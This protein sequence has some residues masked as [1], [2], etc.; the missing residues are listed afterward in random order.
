MSLILDALHRSDQERNHQGAVPGIQTLHGASEIGDSRPRWLLWGPVGLLCLGGL[1]VW[2]LRDGVGVNESALAAV[3]NVS[4]PVTG[5]LPGTTEASA[6]PAVP[7]ATTLPEP[8]PAARP[9]DGVAELYQ[10]AAATDS[11]ANEAAPGPRETAP[12]PVDAMVVAAQQELAAPP[13][14]DNPTPLLQDLPQRTKDEIPSIFFSN[15]AWSNK[16]SEKLVTL[17]GET[18][19]EGDAVATGVRLI[20]ILP[21]SIILDFKGTRFRLRALNSWVNL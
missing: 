10:R 19:R 7:D 14:D 18:R 3:A 4:A 20:E 6:L 15:H 21:E 8:E 9:A 1:L 12:L 16:A 5:P 13:L 17:N 2:A 11:G